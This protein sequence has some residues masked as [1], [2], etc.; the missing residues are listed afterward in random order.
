MLIEMS[1]VQ[2]VALFLFAHQ[3]DEFGVFQK[4]I[5]E[6]RCGR[7]VFC[8][9]LTDG[10]FQGKSSLRRNHESLAVLKQ[11]GVL[12]ED[13]IFAGH[14]LAIPDGGLP[15]RLES[16]IE[17]ID[18]WLA[19]FPKVAAIYL[20]AWE[21]GHHDHDA[22]HAI[23][24]ILAEKTGRMEV[25]RQFSL[26]N[27]YQ[28]AGP[29]FRV[30]L[31]LPMN[32]DLEV[33][34]VPLANRLRFLRHCLSYRSQVITWMGLFPFVVLHYFFFGTQVLQTVSR[35]RI[36]HRPHNGP[37]Y[38]ERRHFYTWEKMSDRLLACGPAVQ[39]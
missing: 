20:P 21:G 30:L 15:D 16:A 35:E 34:K 2:P 24:V 11:L 28:C 9:Y 19:R 1:S 4:I 31:P 23:G 38:Y 5:D 14:K 3:D 22:L 36:R 25:V 18:N 32:G 37:L 33:V 7:R 29:L 13:I 39:K 27:G 12:E 6:N 8:A 17:W 10:V 26:Y